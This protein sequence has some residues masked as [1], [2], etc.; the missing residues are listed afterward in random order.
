M[1]ELTE[2]LNVLLSD[3][4]V[5]YR[6]IQNYHWNIKGEDFFIVHAKLEEY[7]DEINEEI[8]EIAEHILVLEGE[9]LGTMKDYLE[10]ATIA[11]AK[12]EKIESNEIMKN[13]REDFSKIIAECKEVKKMAENAAENVTQALMDDMLKSY[14]KKLWM[15]NQMNG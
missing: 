7:Y 5:L 4:A 8:D 10:K 1:N 13:V 3:L 12:N 14:T 11:E 2:K 9:P 15:L 6:K